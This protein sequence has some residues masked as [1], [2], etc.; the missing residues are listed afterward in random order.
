M[1]AL[2][3]G[4][5]KR[6]TVAVLKLACG[7]VLATLILGLAVWGV[8]TFRA[9]S[10]EAAN[11]PLATLK[12]WPVVNALTNTK[13]HLRTV[14]RNGN[15]Y[16]QFDV[17]GY[18]PVLR[19]TREHE[20]QGTFAIN[21]LDKDGFR[22][23]ERRLALAEMTG[24][25]G[26]DGQPTG[27]SWKGDESMNVDLYRRTTRWDLSWSGLSSVSALEPVTPS[28]HSAPL[29]K[30]LSQAPR[31]FVLPPARPRWR[32]VA[33]WRGLSHGTS[34]DDV[35][36]ILGEPEKIA[37]LGGTV[38]WYYGYPSGGQ[39]TFGQDGRLESWSEP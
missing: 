4:A 7:I 22:L 11:A 29:R 17:I 19:Q 14:W 5:F 12:T 3:T 1:K 6:F 20:G 8:L 39:V 24:E 18:P 34:Q 36:R 37:D 27:L 21:F 13:F 16:Y 23:F 9:R 31:P 25:I 15:I 28:S 32:N 38:I 33:L 26:A 10:E 2:N 30:P 35:K